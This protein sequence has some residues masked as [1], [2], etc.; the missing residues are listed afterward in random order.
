[1]IAAFVPVVLSVMTI[2]L[3]PAYLFLIPWLWTAGALLQRSNGLTWRRAIKTSLILPLLTMIP[4][5]GWM[6]LRYFVVNDF[7][8]LSFGHQNLGGILVQLVSDDELNNLDEMGRAVVAQK[9]SY[10]N[11]GGKFAEGPSG[12]TMTSSKYSAAA[13]REACRGAQMLAGPLSGAGR[14]S[15]ST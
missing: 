3:R 13:A 1:M 2:F 12:A 9:Q 5:L 10:V 8:V 11:S 7:G 14:Q 15:A 6:T 4:L